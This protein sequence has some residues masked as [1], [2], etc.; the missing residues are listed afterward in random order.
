[1]TAFDQNDI[2]LKRLEVAR[3]VSKE[4]TY[5]I[6]ISLISL[7]MLYHIQSFLNYFARIKP[8]SYMWGKRERERDR[9]RQRDRRDKETERQRETERN[10]RRERQTET[11]RQ[12]KSQRDTERQRETER[13]KET[14]RDTQRETER[15]RERQRNRERSNFVKD[16]C[17]LSPSG[18]I[19][20]LQPP[21]LL[22][23]PLCPL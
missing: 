19:S 8:D 9:E 15:D 6:T 14:E 11:E 4:K 23:T 17:V 16:T 1:M 2:V 20:K 7:S 12:R 10:R 21:T 3:S 5:C 18:E 13:Q 22:I